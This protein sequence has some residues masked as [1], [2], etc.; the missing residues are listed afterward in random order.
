MNRLTRVVRLII[1]LCVFDAVWAVCMLA[2]ARNTPWLGVAAACAAA[3][4]QVALSRRGARE[5]AFVVIASTIGAGADVLL[6]SMGVIEFTGT[7]GVTLTGAAWFFAL[8]LNFTSTVNTLFAWL[9]TRWW[10]AALLG[11]VA[12]PF[13]YWA[14]S[15]IGAVS[16]PD[17]AAG[18]I[19]TGIEWAIAMPL[20]VEAGRRFTTPKASP[21][22]VPA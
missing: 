2:A 13:T 14:G 7:E 5:A 3:T 20:L 17:L 16:F 22:E 9:R 4:I 15:R 12:G 6:L 11:G 8:W 1:G 19:A 10:L 21:P 18:L